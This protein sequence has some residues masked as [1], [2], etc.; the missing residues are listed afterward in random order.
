MW[1]LWDWP[2]VRPTGQLFRSQAGHCHP[3]QLCCLSRSCVAWPA[4]RGAP[5]APWPQQAAASAWPSPPL[6]LAVAI[7]QPQPVHGRLLSSPALIRCACSA[8][9]ARTRAASS[10][11]WPSRCWR[12]R[13]V[14]WGG[15]LEGPL[16]LGTHVGTHVLCACSNGSA[17]RWRVSPSA[18]RGS[19]ATWVMPPDAW[20]GL[21]F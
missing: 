5:A 17:E 15:W 4:A 3:V 1:R 8:A 16:A 2:A 19:R 20:T 11:T 13:R 9:T 12:R 14:S 7:A 10:R 6:R 18:K 21:A